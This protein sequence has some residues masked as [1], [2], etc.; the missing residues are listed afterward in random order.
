M[1]MSSF[2]RTLEAYTRL[3]GG[4]GGPSFFDSH[5]GSAERAAANAV[6]ARE[7]RWQ[8][9]PAV[10]DPRATLLAKLDGLAVGQRPEAGMFVG[11]RFVHPELGF[12]IR[13][14]AGW[15]KA[16]TNQAVGASQPQGEAVVFLSADAP[17]GDPAAVADAFI[18]KEQE[19]GRLDVRDAKG[20]KIGAIDAWRVDA[21]GAGVVPVAAQFTFIPFRNATWRVTGASPERLAARYEPQF[22]STARSFRPLTA[23]DVSA[24][25][26]ARLRVTKALGGE[27]VADLSARSG[28][29]WTPAETAVYN[30]VF[31]D[32]RFA[33][34]ETVKITRAEPY[35]PARSAK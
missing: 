16:N 31:A 3:Q 27:T 26:V 20:V 9:D 21:L 12:T 23:G 1:G 28:N 13:F 14:P 5:P 6:R 22:L 8:R 29:A 25:Y 34:G 24:L 33:G 2:L 17:P 7:I 4:V 30:G 35:T 11:D 15:R 18:A 32:H 10:A 19:N